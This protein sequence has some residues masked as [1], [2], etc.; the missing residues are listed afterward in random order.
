MKEKYKIEIEVEEWAK[1]SI[2][3]WQ[4]V[5]DFDNWEYKWNVA[6]TLNWWFVVTINDRKFAL[7][8]SEFATSVMN[9]I[10]NK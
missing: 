10:L 3:I 6:I 2:V 9:N 8:P 1:N 7:S 4:T 5:S